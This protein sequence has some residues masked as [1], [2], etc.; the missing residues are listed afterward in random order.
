MAADIVESEPLV[1]NCT[2]CVLVVDF[3]VLIS[4][5]IVFVVSDSESQSVF[6]RSGFETVFTSNLETVTFIFTGIMAKNEASFSLSSKD[7]KSCWINQATADTDVISTS[8]EQ[9][10]EFEPVP[11]EGIVVKCCFEVE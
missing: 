10:V 11:L 7:G 4:L 2:A 8:I 9:S 3:I 5:D 6:Q 1:D